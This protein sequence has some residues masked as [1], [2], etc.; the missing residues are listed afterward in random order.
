MFRHNKVFNICIIIGLA[1]AIFVA[2]GRMN[3]ERDN[4]TI[5]MVVD[6]SEIESL[7]SQSHKEV[8]FWLNTFKSMGINKAGL[9]EES[10]DSLIN[11]GKPVKAELMRDV[12]KDMD[13]RQNIPENI[14]EAVNND[15][16]FDDDNILISTNS[17]ELYDFIRMGFESRYDESKFI[18]AEKSG[19]YFLY[20]DSGPKDTLYAP[21][22]KYEDSSQKGFIEIRE[23]IYS[24]I[25][26]L[27]LGFDEE[28][29]KEIR[30]A[31]MSVIP[32]TVGYDGWNDEKFEK[33]TL[34]GY[35]K[36]N[37]FPE[38]LIFAG[39]EIIG[40]DAG[41]KLLK[42]YI[43]DHN[44][45]IAMIETTFQ[46][47]NIDQ[48]GLS[49]MV[50][51][52][53][54]NTVRAFTT[55]PYIQNRFQYYNY[56]GSEEIENTF[57]RAITER[58]IRLIYFKPFKEYKDNF[59]YI[60]DVE[61][62][63]RMFESLN[64]RIAEH[65]MSLGSASVMQPYEVNLLFKIIISIGTASAG[66]ILL[67]GFIQL[68][69]KIRIF[70]FAFI[71]ILIIGAYFLSSTWAEL[72]AALGASVVFACLAGL[73]LIKKCQTYS[74]EIKKDEKLSKIIPLGIK[75][76]LI[77]SFISLVGALFTSS[78]ISDINFLLE[79][80]IFRGVKA[81]QLLPLLIFVV[82]YLAYLGLESEHRF[83]KFNINAIKEILTAN[84]KVWVT[85]VGLAVLAA[86]YIYIARTGHETAVEPLTIEMIFRN[87]LEDHLI[88]RP[89]NK[90]FIIAFPA[91]M[92]TV[93]TVIRRM[94]WLPFILGL[95]A[96]IG[97]TSIINTF[98][99]LRTPLYLSFTRTAY[100]L[101]FGIVIGV[102]YV[103]VFEVIIK[104]FI[105]IR[106]EQRNA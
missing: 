106:G 90:E 31:G 81:A 104:I 30:E 101:L 42:E 85:L 75:D 32:R 99:H 51:A 37:N 59:I 79:M 87:F 96:V 20:L 27:S 64:H 24:K 55:W 6:Y 21:K 10:L 34:D 93:Y 103:I 71:S 76:L 25:M 8:S 26:Y 95:A 17:A 84:I 52:T 19:S 38:Y 67:S 41:S 72:L 53:G 35:E 39:S 9:S 58:N 60:T 44:I 12:V 70:I 56:Q 74:C 36:L 43:D 54:Y 77:A 28:K 63:K 13:W 105:R 7:A 4:K 48:A 3:V 18:A 16:V 23:P 11:E 92:L 88:A 61:E 5:D 86:G 66:M 82:L 49:E 78:V 100:S 50:R 33:A 57:Y 98:M 29:V 22:I 69:E 65:G 68:K 91:L 94:R 73:Y 40:Q 47:E 62:Y 80:D 46:R 2:A 45:K 89:R 1:V 14:Q 97:Q 15:P 83:E 102:L